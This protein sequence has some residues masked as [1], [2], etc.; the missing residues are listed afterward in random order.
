LQAIK[1]PNHKANMKPKTEELPE[2]MLAEHPWPIS[3]KGEAIA[4][5]RA[6][7]V[8]ALAEREAYKAHAEALAETCRLA[9]P[10]VEQSYGSAKDVKETHDIINSALA[11][12]EK[13]K[14]S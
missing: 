12:W 14:Q 3:D 13:A 5:W 1:T 2:R 4:V 6:A 9:R 11:A 7:Y 10:L 8:K